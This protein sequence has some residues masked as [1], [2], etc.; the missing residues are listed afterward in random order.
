MLNLPGFTISEVLQSDETGWLAR[1]ERHQQRVLVRMPREDFPSL[2]ELARLKYG[3]ELSAGLDIPGIV[4]VLDLTRHGNSVILAMDDFGGVPL[5]AYQAQAS[6]SIKGVLE[7]G[8]QLAKVVGELHRRRIIHKNIHP[9][10]IL[11]HPR[12]RETRLFNFDIASRLNVENPDF[13][14]P[15]QLDGNLAYISPEQTGRMNR[16]LDYRT[17]LYSLGVTL[18]ELLTGQ[19]PFQATDMMALVYSHLA[20][21]P[22]PPHLLRPEIP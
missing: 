11:V 22:A 18:Y 16:S 5:R 21:T 7:I 1:A 8:I 2:E 9:A 6:G 17:D 10:S 12:T 13:I 20:I 14:S 3:Y 15:E 19:L 4:K